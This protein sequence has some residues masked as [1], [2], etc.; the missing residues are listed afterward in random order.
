MSCG[1]LNTAQDLST[2]DKSLPIYRAIK[3]GLVLCTLIIFGMKARVSGLGRLNACTL[4]LGCLLVYLSVFYAPQTAADDKLARQI[5][6]IEPNRHL[7]QLGFVSDLEDGLARTFFSPAHKLAAGQIE[8][9]MTQAG[10]ST[11]IDAIGNVH[12][13]ATSWNPS[14]TEILIG[15]HYDTVVNGGAYDGSLGIIAG[16]AAA[17][18][19]VITALQKRQHQP[20]NF[21]FSELSDVRISPAEARGLLRHPVHLIAFT[22]EEGVRFKSTFLGSKAVAGAF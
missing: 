3:V 21:S 14:A 13:Y 22:D 2:P 15:S 7:T 6:N 9:W 4:K 12:G 5:L 16:I 17:K 11:W 1:V 20:L 18:W 10:L 8:T 19:A